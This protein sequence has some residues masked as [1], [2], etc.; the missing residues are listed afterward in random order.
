[1]MRPTASDTDTRAGVAHWRG[2]RGSAV[3][4]VRR[5]TK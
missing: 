3:T 5:R 4:S 1:M 2:A